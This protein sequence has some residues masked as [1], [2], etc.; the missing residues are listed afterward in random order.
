MLLQTLE[1]KDIS[2]CW[3]IFVFARNSDV[4]APGPS[5]QSVLLPPSAGAEVIHQ[6]R[7]NGGQTDLLLSSRGLAGVRNFPLFSGLLADTPAVLVP[8]SRS[9]LGHH[10]HLCPCSPQP[11]NPAAASSACK[12]LQ[13]FPEAWHMGTLSPQPVYAALFHRLVSQ[14]VL[15]ARN[16][17]PGPP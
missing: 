6:R 9:G 14:S 5:P 1:S 4:L 11:L 12:L 3:D 15:G 2:L 8:P 16:P 13:K 10:H 17:S 7:V